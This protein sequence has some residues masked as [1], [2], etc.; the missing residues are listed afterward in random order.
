MTVASVKLGVLDVYTVSSQRLN[1]GCALDSVGDGTRGCVHRLM[2]H[3]TD[4]LLGLAVRLA[5]QLS[6]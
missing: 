6:A 1:S 2:T 3:A 5:A 4:A